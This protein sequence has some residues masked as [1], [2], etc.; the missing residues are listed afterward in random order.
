METIISIFIDFFLLCKHSNI[1]RGS[2]CTQEQE[3]THL[4]AG[5]NKWAIG[6][7]NWRNS[8]SIQCQSGASNSKSSYRCGN[9]MSWCSWNDG[10]LKPEL[11]QIT[12]TVEHQQVLQVLWPVS[13]CTGCAH[14]TGTSQSTALAW[15]L[16]AAHR[17]VQSQQLPPARNT[18]SPACSSQLPTITT[19]SSHSAPNVFCDPQEKENLS[20]CRRHMSTWN[21]ISTKYCAKILQEEVGEE[22]K[23]NEQL[24]LHLRWLIKEKKND[25][26]F[27]IPSWQ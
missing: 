14:S 18:A 19:T 17:D 5:E 10:E 11:L 4:A 22:E 9:C 15:Q 12:L 1:W 24:L 7:L 6:S 2:Q 23:Q 13:V 20:K 25:R 21:A 27:L 16:W 8:I 3:Q 26:L